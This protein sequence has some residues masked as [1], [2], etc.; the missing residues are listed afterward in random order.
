MSK[1]T[2]H[3]LVQAALFAALVCA[4]TALLQIPSPI[5]YFNL[6]DTVV[7]LGAFLLAPLWGAGAGGVGAALADVL[8]GFVLYAPATLVIKFL[9]ALTAAFLLRSQKTHRIRGAV[10][11]A[12]AGEFVMAAG[13]FCYEWALYG[14]GGSTEALLTT[15]LPQAA[16]NAAAAILLFLVLDRAH[17][18][19][20]FGGVSTHDR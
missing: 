12:V 20:R 14:L 19:E 10:L 16:V 2:L 5:G 9:T 6:G 17:V 3:R 15:N 8:L 18:S 4:A 7:L 1:L 11:G 13:Y